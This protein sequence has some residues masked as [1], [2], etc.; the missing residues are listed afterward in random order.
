MSKNYINIKAVLLMNNFIANDFDVEI[1]EILLVHQ[2]TGVPN[3]KFEQYKRGRSFYGLTY[4]QSGK[5]MY[6]SP[7]NEF[8]VTSGD[9]IF[10]P[11][12]SS[13]WL[14]NAINDT[15]HHITVNFNLKPSPI[16]EALVD[17]IVNTTS[18]TLLH[19]QNKLGF[20][21]LFNKLVTSWTERN[22]G[23]MLQ[24]RYLLYQILYEF[25]IENIV[26]NSN[27]KNVSLIQPAKE[28]IDTFYMNP[29]SNQELASICGISVTHFRRIFTELHGSSPIE[30]LN[31]VRIN[32]AKDML[33]Y[34]L[35]S[36]D[37]IARLIG[38]DDV[39]YF[40]RLFKK[41]VGVTPAQFKKQIL[42]L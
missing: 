39:N 23:Y 5:V 37:E 33:I 14:A 11:E 32:R 40:C 22:P 35:Y 17:K 8:Y 20:E 4:A 31:K 7:D 30:Y 26:L 18:L 25:L 12:N 1:S 16:A 38:I 6:H 28:Y 21:Q 2:Y 41:K 29:I 19:A 36:T 27:S 42:S 15:Y 13:Y 34:N 24:C 3:F 9:I 10:L